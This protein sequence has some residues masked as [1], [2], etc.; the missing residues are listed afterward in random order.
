MWHQLD[1]SKLFLHHCAHCKEENEEE[2]AYLHHAWVFLKWQVTTGHWIARKLDQPLNG[3]VTFGKV[4]DDV[5]Q[6]CRNCRA[7]S[8]KQ[9]CGKVR[10]KGDSFVFLI[11]PYFVQYQSICCCN[12][13]CV[14]DKRS[15]WIM[16]V[17]SKDK[18]PTGLWL[19]C[20]RL[21]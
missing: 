10:W 17:V 2:G 20:L 8:V 9:E 1:F 5:K 15:V 12:P 11:P 21:L 18:D 13:W 3:T 6:C 4:H 7:C 16:M 14:N 19:H